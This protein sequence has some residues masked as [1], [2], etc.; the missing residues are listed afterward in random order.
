MGS[1]LI[2]KSSKRLLEDM[3]ILKVIYVKTLV[4]LQLH[5]W[6]KARVIMGLHGKP[7]YT[8]Q[9]EFSMNATRLY[10]FFFQ[11]TFTTT[12]TTITPSLHTLTPRKHI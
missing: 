11:S 1:S 2:S 9:R 7:L 3:R 5:T 10:P 8:L 12:T 6:K 4:Q